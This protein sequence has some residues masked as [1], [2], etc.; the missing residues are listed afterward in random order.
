MGTNVGGIPDC[1]PSEGGFLVEREVTAEQLAD[2][3]DARV[4]DAA[5]Y[6]A[7]VDGA[8]REM[9]R[10]SWDSSARRLVEIWNSGG[11]PS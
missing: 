11:Q 2:A 10:V 1:V 6:R 4:F 8:I 7:I 9:N 5:A 3:I